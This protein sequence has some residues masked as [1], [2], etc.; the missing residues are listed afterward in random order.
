VICTLTNCVA[1]DLTLPTPPHTR[2]ET[3][4]GG[5]FIL[6]ASPP[7][8]PA[9]AAASPHSEKAAVRWSARITAAAREGRNTATEKRNNDEASLTSRPRRRPRPSTRDVAQDAA[10]APSPDTTKNLAAAQENAV[11]QIQM[12]A[13]AHAKRAVRVLRAVMDSTRATPASRV[14]AAIAMLELGGNKATQ[15]AADDDSV[16]A[17]LPETIRHIIVEPEQPDREGVPA[18]AAA[19]PL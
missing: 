9:R 16:N 11:A 17:P 6:R 12:L 10:D 19:G 8:L 7:P 18:A 3:S 5:F 13:Q 14:R 2:P 1:T 15:P 4:A